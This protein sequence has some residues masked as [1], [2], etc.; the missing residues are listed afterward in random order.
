[1]TANP[2]LKAMANRILFV[3][4]TRI[5]DAVLSLGVLGR[6]LA[7]YPDARV[8][9]ACGRAAAPL[10]E[11]VPGLDRVII[12][13]KKPYSLHWL[14]LWAQCVF[15]F[16]TVLV[17]LRNTPMTYLIPARH[18][19]R[20][21]RKG[22]G[23]RLQ[24]YAQVMG[25]SG[26]PPTPVIWLNDAHRARAA[27]LVP[28]GALVLAIGP[29]A[30]WAGKTWPEDRFIAL[31]RRLTGPGGLLAGAKVAVFGHGDER[32]MV[33]RLLAD[34]PADRC[35]DL[36]GK[37]SLLEAYACLQR[38]SFYV[39]NDSGLMHLAAV[40][41]VPTLGLFG[42]TQENLYGPWGDHCAV[43]RGAGFMESYPDGYDW[44]NSDSLL[45]SLEVEKVEAAV[46]ILWDRQAEAAQ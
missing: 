33:E 37:V 40:A 13:D 6:L 5:G 21:G 19:Y 12:L 2:V 29:T 3:T 39:G 4:A 36:I 30:N 24:R 46:K 11:T 10:F 32:P 15:G 22:E 7:D 31:V 26:P 35:I 18:Q 41:A 34:I 16:W 43:V 14:G 42:P 28:C 9:I 23:H 25:I 8:T 27:E 38:S 44:S 1:M 20:M 45:Q 17:D